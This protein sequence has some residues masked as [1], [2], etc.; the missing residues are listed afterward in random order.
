MSDLRLNSIAG[1]VL[2]S[3]LGVM[4]LGVLG[5]EVLHPHYPETPG[6]LPEVDLSANA[7]GAPAAP[8]GPPDFGLLFADEAQ[9]TSLVSQGERV[10]GVCVSCHSFDPGGANGT[11]PALHGVFGRAA[12]AHPGYAYSEAL[13][14]YGQ[15]WSY[16]SLDAYLTS[17]ARAIPGNKMAFAG[18]RDTEDRV[19]LIAYL[20]S[21]TPNPPPLPAPL[22]QAAPAEAAEGAAEGAAG[23]P[24]P[25]APAPG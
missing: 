24:T 3:V 21:L 25:A 22:P 19:A 6:Y 16:E 15:V 11:G 10:K 1:A 5:E 2:A 17:P 4:G 20:R 12:G 18:I 23:E 14:A 8:E 7:G 9:L 13:V